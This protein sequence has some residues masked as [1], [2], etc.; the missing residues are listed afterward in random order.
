MS[1]T[2]R[3]PSLTYGT[4]G[5]PSSTTVAR[6]PRRRPPGA[7]GTAVLRW[8]ATGDFQARQ[9]AGSGF[10]VTQPIF[11]FTPGGDTSEDDFLDGLLFTEKSRETT[12]VRITNPL[13]AGDFVDVERIDKISFTGPDGVV[14]TFVLNN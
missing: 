13:D 10:A 5:R 3:G 14:R 7:T 2:V 1:F 8:G 6:I 4:I 12:T 9:G 11:N